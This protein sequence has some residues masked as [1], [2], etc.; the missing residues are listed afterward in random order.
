MAEVESKRKGLSKRFSLGFPTTVMPF[1]KNALSSSPWDSPA[2]RKRLTRQRKL[3]HASDGELGLT[4]TH[5]RSKSLPVSPKSVSSR[6]RSPRHWSMSAVPQPLPLP[7][8]NSPRAGNSPTPAPGSYMSHQATRQPTT[9]V[10]TKSPKSPTYR[11]R[12]FQQDLNVDSAYHNFRLDVPARSAPT[13]G[14]SSPVLSPRRFGTVDIFQSSFMARQEFQTSSARITPSPDYSPLHSPSPAGVTLLSNQRSLPAGPTAMPEGNN[15]NVHPLPLPPGVS[16][17]SQSA[18]S[19]YIIDRSDVS[20]MKGQW[21]KGKLIGRGTYGSVYAAVNSINGASCAMKEVD[22]IPDDSKSAE[23]IKQLEQEI[24]VLQQLKHPNIVEYYGSEIVDD[25][26]CIYLEI[27]HP[28]SI[29]KYVQE[30]CGAMT[31]SV[32][33]NFTRHILSGLEYLHSMN[34]IHRDI[35][36]ANLLVDASGVVKLADFGLAKHLSGYVTDLSLKGSPHWMA[37]ELLQAVMRK[38]SNPEDAFAVD[39]WSLGCTVIEMLTGK[40]PWSEYD[41]VQAL[42]SVLNKSPP[43]PETLSLDGKDFL[44]WCFQRNPANRPSAA[45][46]LTHPFIQNL[47]DQNVSVTM[48]E[49]SGMKLNDNTSHSPRD[50]KKQKELM[51]PSPGTWIKHGKL[52]SNDETSP[53]IYP[54]TSKSGA[55]T[56]HS[57]RSTLEVL[58]SVSLPQFNCSSYKISLSNISNSLQIGAGNKYPSFFRTNGKEVSPF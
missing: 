10:A 22:L 37:P 36:G 20:S 54:E 57:P 48:Q 43:I 38:D 45:K 28:G 19:R 42:F 49:F 4:Q 18:T 21:I 12:G 58:P 30:H 56:R 17:P 6:S 53:Q 7:D 14:F 27:V 31:E 8:F 35:K 3:R 15:V 2:S 34:T 32:V 9:D 24:Q 41:G 47:H 16:R 46:L 55:S 5:D 33:R 25:R 52:P 50:W 1:L 39:I 11:R 23:C 40:P 44:N 51:P 13:T 29:N 26:F